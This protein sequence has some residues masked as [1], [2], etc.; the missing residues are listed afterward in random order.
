MDGEAFKL[1]LPTEL[2]LIV[3]G[4]P[5]LDFSALQEAAAYED[6]DGFNGNYVYDIRAWLA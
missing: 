4:S 3:V 6:T 1:L 2:E 5:E